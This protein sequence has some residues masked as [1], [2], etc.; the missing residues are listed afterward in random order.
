MILNNLR[1]LRLIPNIIHP[2]GQL[3][4]PNERVTPDGDVI[5]LGVVHEE[6]G[7]LP[8]IRVLLVVDLVPLHRVLRGELAEG[9]L[10]D[11]RVLRVAEE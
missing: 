10:D 9:G 4:V 8:T 2:P 1:K 11:A 5:L 3:R 6:V 7:T